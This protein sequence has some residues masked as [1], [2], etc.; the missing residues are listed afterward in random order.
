M[1]DAQA[2]AHSDLSLSSEFVEL[3]P[4]ERFRAAQDKGGD[5]WVWRRLSARSWV[6]FMRCESKDSAELTVQELLARAG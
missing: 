4:D 1:T 2:Q 5:W 3:K 6:T